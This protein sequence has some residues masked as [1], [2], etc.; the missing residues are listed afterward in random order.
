MCL[1]NE[2]HSFYL[3]ADGVGGRAAGEV[4][5]RLFCQAAEDILGNSDAADDGRSL[6][7]RV[8]QLAHKNIQTIACSKQQCEGM[9][10]TAEV[11]LI[12]GCEAVIGHV[13][14]SRTY[15]YRNGRLF[16]LTEDHSFVFEQIKAGAISKDQ[17]RKHP[18][19]NVILRAVGIEEHVKIDIV[20]TRIEVGD[21]FLLNT[22][23]LSDMVEDELI[24]KVL[25]M[26]L[27]LQAKVEMLVA[28]AKSAGGKDNIA[29]VLLQV[30]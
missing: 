8:F 9:G 14:D 7:E 4:A 16:L 18:M 22:D 23:G 1:A 29:V 17:A 24:E 13:G 5:S 15:R 25:S 20:T 27:K 10:C 19:K 21:I 6:V 2:Q 30:V 26:N 11:M 3:V 28:L 12:E